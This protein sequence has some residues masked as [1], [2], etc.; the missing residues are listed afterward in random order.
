MIPRLKPGTCCWLFG[1]RLAESGGYHASPLSPMLLP[2][3]LNWNMRD[4]EKTRLYP[5]CERAPSLQVRSLHLTPKQVDAYLP[6]LPADLPSVAAGGGDCIPQP[7]HH[8][9]KYHFSSKAS[10]LLAMSKA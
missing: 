1:V 6:A 10:D 7:P 4:G 9:L 5:V 8:I 2:M 3:P